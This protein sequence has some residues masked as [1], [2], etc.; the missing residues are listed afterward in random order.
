MKTDFRFIVVKLKINS[1]ISSS[2]SAP[3]IHLPL[4][5]SER[6]SNILRIETSSLPKRHPSE[7]LLLATYFDIGIIRTLFSP[8]WL[9]DG[10]LWCLEYLQKRTIDISDEILSDSLTT[11]VIPKNILRFKSLSIPQINL[12]NEQNY[13]KYLKNNLY[14]EQ[15]T[16]DIIE[17]QSMMTTT[18]SNAVK[19][20]TTL[21]N[22]PMKYF[23][24]KTSCN[25][26]Y[27]KKR[28][29]QLLNK[30]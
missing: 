22:I 2:I 16:N 9:T 13:Y 24:G 19:Q 26:F 4:P 28:E 5:P 17:Q 7:Y 20:S 12:L 27:I 15:L 3:F 11:G 10:Y 18:T 1:G 25:N 6:S 30:K 14:N 23:S 8:S 29:K 21:L